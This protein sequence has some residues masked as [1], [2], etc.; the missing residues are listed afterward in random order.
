MCIFSVTKRQAE[1]AL[2][3]V[4]PGRGGGRGLSLGDKDV[5]VLPSLHRPG[6][7]GTDS[8]PSGFRHLREG[9]HFVNENES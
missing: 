9:C 6:C 3:K 2:E 8:A 5:F 4:S 1:S 7:K